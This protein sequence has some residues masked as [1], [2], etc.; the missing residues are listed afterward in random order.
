MPTFITGA[1]GFIGNKLT[2]RLVESGEIVHALVRKTSDISILQH[3]NIK[4]FSGDV[5][6][7]PEV[8]AAMKGCKYV[9][10]L[11]AYARSY[12]KDNQE[13]FRI[14]V[15]GTKN[16]C[17]VAKAYNVKKAVITSSVVTFGPTGREPVDETIKRDES[18]FYTIYEHSK[19]VAEKAVVEFIKQGLPATIVN[20][21]RIFGPGLMNESNS[22]TLMIQMYLKGKMRTILGNGNGIGN[23][24][25][26][27]DV[28]KGHILAMEKGRIDEKY[29]LGGD[30]V[31]YNE[32]FN[33][34]DEVSGKKYFQF[35]IPTQV[36][37]LFGQVERLRGKLFNSYP[38]ITPDWV[39]TFALD[40]VYSVKKAETELGYTYTPIKE[41]L[42]I[43]IKWLNNLGGEKYEL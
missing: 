22:V 26:V 14:N 28:V 43:T 23:Y 15:D 19:Y 4:I 41:A 34:I 17:K 8:E 6:N 21:T 42:R 20:P 24:G 12:A 37:L 16:I 32:F 31:S 40:W 30:N 7:L 5:T 18:K 1:T 27:D 33:V 38:L 13:Y 25:F 36:A 35:K 39:K 9:Y 10:H 29:I 2:H 11:A 3:P